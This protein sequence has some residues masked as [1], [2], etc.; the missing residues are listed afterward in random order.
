MAAHGFRGFKV[1]CG[2]KNRLGDISELEQ[3]QRPHAWK[4][5][6]QKNGHERPGLAHLKSWKE[7]EVEMT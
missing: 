7:E 1:P 5:V 6:R 2:G 3:K 4:G